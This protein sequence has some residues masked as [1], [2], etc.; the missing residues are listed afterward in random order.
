MGSSTSLPAVE[1][2]GGWAEDCEIEIILGT[3]DSPCYII[4][5]GGDGGAGMITEGVFY[6]NGQPSLELSEMTPPSPGSAGGDALSFSFLSIG[7]VKIKIVNGLIL[8]GGGGGGG[9]GYSGTSQRV[10]T[11]SNVNIGG[12]GGGGSGYGKGGFPFAESG[13]LFELSGLGG[14]AGEPINNSSVPQGLLGKGGEG[15]FFGFPGSPGASTEGRKIVGKGGAAGR[16]IVWHGENVPTVEGHNY[17]L[18]EKSFDLSLGYDSSV[19]Y[20]DGDRVTYNGKSWRKIG[21]AQEAPGDSSEHWTEDQ[22]SNIY[23]Y[24]ESLRVTL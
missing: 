3:E 16:A 6:E 8:A 17:N 9:G 2:G 4:G 1:L 12:G 13:S 11:S 10:R 24:G 18:S 20:V 19:T 5:K 22:D 14:T 21:G 23:I 15:G 7:G